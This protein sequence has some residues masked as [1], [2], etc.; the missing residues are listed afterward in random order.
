MLFR[1]IFDARNLI[2]LLFAPVV[3]WAA[4]LLIHLI[5]VSPEA[6]NVTGVVLV[7]ILLPIAA[8]LFIVWNY[9]AIARHGDVLPPEIP[10]IIGL[11][12]THPLYM[13]ALKA[14]VDGLDAVNT[15]A[16]DWFVMTITVPFSNLIIATYD[17]TFIAVPLAL[18]AMVIAGVILRRRGNGRALSRPT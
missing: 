8:V 2:P 15:T 10:A 3:V 9:R 6:G 13:L 1:R 17:G 18:L 11:L 16:K 5:P 12:Y 7:T 14:A 4:N